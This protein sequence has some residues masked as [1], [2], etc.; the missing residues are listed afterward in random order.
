[1][2]RG[3]MSEKRTSLL[4]E[5]LIRIYFKDGTSTGGLCG[6]PDYQ[7]HCSQKSNSHMLSYEHMYSQ[8][9]YCA[10]FYINKSVNI[11]H[12]IGRLVV[13]PHCAG[14]VVT[15]GHSY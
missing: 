9:L 5:V 10:A 8:C 13:S 2:I 3:K 7:R 6:S 1:M 14:I 11:P 15:Y 4:S 12:Y